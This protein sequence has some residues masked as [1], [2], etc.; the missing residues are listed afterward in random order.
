[1]AVAAAARQAREALEAPEQV[2]E[3]VAPEDLVTERILAT[4]A[5][6][7]RVLVVMVPQAARLVAAEAAAR[8][9]SQEVHIRHS[10]EA[11]ATQAS[12][13]SPTTRP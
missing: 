11:R 2:V 3:A 12:L 13:F 7:E 10:Q 4:A 1:M 6:A 9:D 5:M 8:T